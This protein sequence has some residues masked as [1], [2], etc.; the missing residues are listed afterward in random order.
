MANDKRP[1]D[2]KSLSVA[3]RMSLIE[4]IWDSIADEDVS[5]LPTK[6]QQEELER[7][8]AD[9]AQNPGTGRSWEAIKTRLLGNET[10]K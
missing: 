9:E 3:E 10:S 8:L 5:I 4:E 7:R 1:Y 6:A 2:F